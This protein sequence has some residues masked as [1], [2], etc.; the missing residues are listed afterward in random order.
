[1]KWTTMA[2]LYI[3]LKYTKDSFKLLIFKILQ[4]LHGT[5][6]SQNFQLKQISY[7][8]RPEK[9]RLKFKNPFQSSPSFEKYT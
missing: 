9:N 6:N 8:N 1:M 5:S 2:V 7:V 4:M 3:L